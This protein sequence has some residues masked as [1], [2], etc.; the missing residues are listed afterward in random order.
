MNYASELRQIISQ[1]KKILDAEQNSGIELPPVN[2]PEAEIECSHTPIITSQAKT[3]TLTELRTDLGDCTRCK[4]SK[5]RKNIVFGEGSEKA[6]LV[7]IGEGPGR[8]EDIAGRPFVGE[9]GQ[10][11]TKIIENGIG[12]KREDVYICNIVKCRPPTIATLK[13]MKLTAAFLS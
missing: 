7:F 13:R 12:I 6:R 8:D 5:G 4:L 2:I 10:L 1:T 9:A 11:L 3:A